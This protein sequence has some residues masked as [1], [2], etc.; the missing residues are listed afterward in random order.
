M[1]AGTAMWVKSHHTYGCSRSQLLLNRRSFHHQLGGKGTSS[2][3]MLNSVPAC[4]LERLNT[5]FP[6]DSI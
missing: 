1:K 6:N 2:L 4:Y 3:A 5:I